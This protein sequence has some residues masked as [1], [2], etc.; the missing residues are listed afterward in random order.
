M[1]SL[2]KNKTDFSKEW[3]LNIFTEIQK[4]WDFVRFLKIHENYSYE[5]QLLKPKYSYE[6]LLIYGY[7]INP[8]KMRSLSQGKTHP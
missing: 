8:M 1:L 2:L 4:L 6:T 3:T 7:Y 5:F